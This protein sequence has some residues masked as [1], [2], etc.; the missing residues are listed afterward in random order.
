MNEKV[1]QAIEG[2]LLRFESGEIPEAIAYSVF[3]GAD[4]PSA[5]WSL[6]N[7]ILMIVSGTRDARGF[8]QWNEVGRYIK[9]G[10]KAFY[11]L[12]PRLVK[13]K[14]RANRGRVS[15]TEDE[16]IEEFTSEDVMSQKT[17]SRNRE[18]KIISGFLTVPVFRVEDTEGEPLADLENLTLPPLP[19]SEV[20]ESWGVPV[21]AIPGNYSIRGAFSI[22]K[23]EITLATEEETVFFHE[24]AHVAHQKL[25]G[26]LRSG[27][28]WKQEIVAEL[29]AAALCSIV[30]KTSRTLGNSYQYISR[31]AEEA[32]LTPVQACLKVIKD[33]EGVL[34][35]IL[36][37][38]TQKGGNSHG[39]IIREV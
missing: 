35:L 32:N 3:P 2:I 28:D 30:G 29:S 34:N 19:L 25:F 37:G 14:S 21:K 33:V 12:A 6:M 16:G 36:N 18:E 20:A 38:A 9:E 26:K 31:Y 15:S 10:A 17:P 13:K 39:N 1:K 5:K 4:I 22:S 11:I 24:L 27:Q 8:R 7:R 23:N